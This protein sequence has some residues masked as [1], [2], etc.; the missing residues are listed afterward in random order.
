[1][2][3]YQSADLKFDVPADW[4]DRTITA[5][6]APP[7]P[8]RKVVPNLVLTREAGDGRESVTAYADRQLV[9]FAKR[10]DDFELEQRR[11]RPLGGLPAVELTF[12]WHN[13]LGVLRQRQLCVLLRGHTVLNLTLSALAE[14]FAAVEPAFDAILASLHFPEAVGLPNRARY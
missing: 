13:P 9:E 11:E 1:M 8:G 12:T 5:F 2:P 14:D 4:Q 6:A 7:K 3:R 10:L